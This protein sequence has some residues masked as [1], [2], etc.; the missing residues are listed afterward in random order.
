[1]PPIQQCRCTEGNSRVLGWEIAIAV[2]L[3]WCAAYLIFP[4]VVRIAM[5]E[6]WS[7]HHSAKLWAYKP[8]S[9]QT[10]RNQTAAIAAIRTQV[11]RRRKT[12]TNR[13][14]RFWNLCDKFTAD[15]IADDAGIIIYNFQCLFCNL[16]I[17]FLLSFVDLWIL[18]SELLKFEREHFALSQPLF[19]SD[20]LALYRVI[21]VDRLID[22]VIYCL[23]N[24]AIL[25]IF[26]A[27]CICLFLCL[28][29]HFTRR[30]S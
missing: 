8:A 10:E 18:K 17:Y 14:P 24:I 27:Y 1:M 30:H 12:V 28:L 9:G 5:F 6:Q 11:S 25:T 20:F 7:L 29:D 26:S 2:K 19:A 22:F 23:R 15:L 4:V 16:L 13:P 3:L 21:F